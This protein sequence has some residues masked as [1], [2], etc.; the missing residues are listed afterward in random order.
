MKYLL[1]KS[2]KREANNFVKFTNWPKCNKIDAATKQQKKMR[3]DRNTV[4]T[5][6]I[7]EPFGCYKTSVP[8]ESIANFSFM[9]MP[10]IKC[11][12]FSLETHFASLYMS[13][14]QANIY[15]DFFRCWL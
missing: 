2:Q 9:E 10:S 14:I 3:I 7:T 6:S 11:Y 12:S 8:L 13:V 1:I 15:G 5:S 4:K